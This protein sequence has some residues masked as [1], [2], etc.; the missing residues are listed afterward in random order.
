MPSSSGRGRKSSSS[1]SSSGSG[2]S[3]A[4]S[5]PAAASSSVVLHGCAE[6]ISS[7]L[8]GQYSAAGVLPIRR[9]T[10]DKVEALLLA[11]MEKAKDGAAAVYRLQVIGALLFCFFACFL[12]PVATI[13]A[14]LQC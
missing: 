13:P 12:L 1:S 3:T 7:L 4:S 2:S 6:T 9:T 11:K 8:A 14:F 5:T 10:S